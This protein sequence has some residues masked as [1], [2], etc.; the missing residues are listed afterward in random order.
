MKLV[1]AAVHAAIFSFGLSCASAQDGRVGGVHTTTL[2]CSPVGEPIVGATYSIE[3]DTQA[4]HPKYSSVG[5]RVATAAVV[6]NPVPQTQSLKLYRQDEL[7]AIYELGN[8]AA[9]V[10]KTDGSVELAHISMS[11]EYRTFMKCAKEVQGQRRR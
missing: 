7:V 11:H 6:P 5:L 9:V 8:L 1:L 3:H 4:L 2:L 10:S